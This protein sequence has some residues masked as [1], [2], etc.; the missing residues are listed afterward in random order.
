MTPS[1]RTLKGSKTKGFRGSPLL[2]PRGSN[3]R[4]FSNIYGFHHF[5]L[6]IVDL[7]TFFCSL[8][9]LHSR[10][11]LLSLHPF[12]NVYHYTGTHTKEVP[13]ARLGLFFFRHTS[14]LFLC[15]KVNRDGCKLE[16]RWLQTPT[17]LL[18]LYTKAFPM[19]SV[20]CWPVWE[21]RSAHAYLLVR[22][23]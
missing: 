21:S 6:K 8:V 13:I 17:S 19:I 16:E 20:R 4:G 22:L 15:R 12:F 7:F 1:V 18:L 11:A 5:Y 9:S 23:I 3:A 10:Q 14:M 2:C